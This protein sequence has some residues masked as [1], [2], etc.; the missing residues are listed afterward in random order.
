MVDDWGTAGSLLSGN[1]LPIAPGTVGNGVLSGLGNAASNMFSNPA[2]LAALAGG[3]AGIAGNSDITSSQNST[4][5]TNR[6]TNA[7]GSVTGN[8]TTAQS[9]G[10]APWLQGYAQ[11]FV[12]RSRA[13]ANAPSSN[14]PMDTARELMTRYATGGDPLVNA[15]RAQQGNV[16]GGG[17]LGGN[18][19]LDSVARGIG[20][21]MG[22]A[23]AIGTRANTAT[24]FN[25]DGNSPAA[26]SAYGQT[27]FVNDRAFAD[28]LGQTINNLYFGNY[29]G[30]RQAQDAASRS[31]LGFGQ[32]GVQNAS[33]LYG[34]G[35]QDFQR[36]YFQN[37]EYGRSINPAFGSQSTGQSTTAQNSLQNVQNNSS[38][39]GTQQSVM[40]AP[41]NVLAGTGGALSALSIYNM[42]YPRR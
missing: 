29:Q 9:Q 27:Q 12:D 39:Q 23:Y 2:L 7:S 19:Y 37:Q 4:S 35:A 25:A 15:A 24:R 40:Q 22:D 10:L 8:A 32:F 42:L 3:V 28:S 18:P 1:P 14:A 33:N 34:V 30:E 26:K 31:S 16:I 6:S 36:P 11:D 5:N 38:T 13:L 17:M 21:R 20:D 41:N